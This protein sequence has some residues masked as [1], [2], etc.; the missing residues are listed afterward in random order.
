MVSTD[1]TTRFRVAVV[2]KGMIGSAAARHLSGQ[3]DGVALVRADERPVRAEH[4]DLFGIHYGEGR[5]VASSTATRS[6]RA[7]PNARH[8]AK[9]QRGF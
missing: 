3:T 7:S 1:P 8:P 4:H 5:S 2:G 9:D 6:G